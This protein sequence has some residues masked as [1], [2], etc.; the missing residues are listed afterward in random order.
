MESRPGDVKKRLQILMDVW[1]RLVG[2]WESE[3]GI[4]RDQV[5]DLLRESYRAARLEPLRGASLP[6]DIF[7]KEMASLYVVGKYGMGLDRQYPELFD[8]IFSREERYEEALRLLLEGSPDHIKDLLET[9]L[10]SLDDN[11][12][13]R[14][15]RVLFTKVYFGFSSEEE[16]FQ[17]LRKLAEAIPEKER[18]A[19]KYARFYIAFRVA[20]SIASGTVRNRIVK[21]VMKQAS[22]LQLR[23][24]RG[25][26][27]DDS[28][29]ASIARDVFHVNERVI[30]QTLSVEEGRRRRARQGDEGERRTG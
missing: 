13:A 21:E 17:A 12:I 14:M 26:I 24:L 28:Y 30:R 22:A 2:L 3:G 7:D 18:I 8:A 5:V 16:L 25:V 10:G 11:E 1:M 23:H 27:P 29:I 20:S 15:L 4:G 19:A 6:P 9:I